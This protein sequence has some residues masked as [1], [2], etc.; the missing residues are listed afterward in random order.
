[1]AELVFN[2]SDFESGKVRTSLLLLF[3]YEHLHM[4]PPILDDQ[5]RF[6]YISSIRTLDAV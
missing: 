5:Q 6:T 1:M 4:K 2:L 3:L